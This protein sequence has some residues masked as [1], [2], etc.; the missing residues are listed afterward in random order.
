MWSDLRIAI[1]TYLVTLPFVLPALYEA[2]TI[3]NVDFWFLVAYGYGGSALIVFASWK[4]VDF[5]MKD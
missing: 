3:Q 5:L 1:V 4:I 2:S